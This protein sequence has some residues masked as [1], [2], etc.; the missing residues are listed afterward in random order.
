MN[1]LIAC[2]S[3]E[4]LTGMEMYMY[5]LSRELEKRGHA[6]TIVSRIG[7]GE[8]T[9]R[10]RQNGVRTFIYSNYPAGQNY[11]ILHLNEMEPAIF[12]LQHHPRTPAISTVH[13]QYPCENPYLDH[14]VFRYVCIRPEIQAKIVAVEKIPIEQTLV[15]YNGIDIERFNKNFTATPRA[16]KVVV[17]PGTIHDLRRPA[18]WHLAR[19]AIA[20]DFDAVFVGNVYDKNYPRLYP[21]HKN[22]YYYRAEWD[23]EKY[24]HH[25]D[26]TAGILLGRTTI[27]GWACGLPGWIYDV[28]LKGNIRSV[29]LYQPPADM[30]P[31][32]IKAVTTKYERLYAAAI[33]A[34]K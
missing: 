6:V 17:F 20:E 14:R 8:I 9:E 27:E 1:I 29:A 26:E 25:S 22:V 30:E 31:F 13:S 21:K 3:F 23:V 16:R 19:R 12:A 18:I 24:Y 10:A 2:L 32:D 33:E 15:I 5:E 34:K 4:Y 7:G 11:D 28:D